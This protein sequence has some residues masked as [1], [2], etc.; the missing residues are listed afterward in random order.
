MGPLLLVLLLTIGLG[1]LLIFFIK[2]TSKKVPGE[3]EIPLPPELQGLD[4]DQFYS[5]SAQLLEKLGLQIREGY[6]DKDFEADI[7]ADNPQPLIGGPVIVHIHLY[8]EDG[9]ITSMDVMNFASNLVGERRGKGIYLTTGHFAPDV[10]TLPEL[11]PMDFI[12]G[13]KLQDLIS[14]YRILENP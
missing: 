12:D 6:R 4:F 11:P 2:K 1:F 14:Q 13:K 7:Y 9:R 5:L 10:W 3:I 8:P